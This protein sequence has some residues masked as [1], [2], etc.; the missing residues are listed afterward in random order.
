MSQPRGGKS[1]SGLS[2]RAGSKPDTAS[3][4]AAGLAG[5]QAGGRWAGRGEGGGMMRH[6]VQ[7]AAGCQ[8]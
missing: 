3:A 4:H 7:Q 5:E 6:T 1:G 2:S 8:A